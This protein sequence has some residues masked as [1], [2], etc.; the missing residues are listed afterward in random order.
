MACSSS[1]KPTLASYLLSGIYALGNRQSSVA[2]GCSAPSFTHPPL[3][4]PCS[5]ENTVEGRGV[6]KLALL[7]PATLCGN[8]LAKV[9][10]VTFHDR[11]NRH[12]IG[13]G[14]QAHVLDAAASEVRRQHD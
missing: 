12:K 11:A 6:A 9:T 5:S 1:H 10:F 8:M 2:H 3:R 4:L 7:L 13:E 14:A